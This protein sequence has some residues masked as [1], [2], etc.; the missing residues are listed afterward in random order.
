VTSSEAALAFA[1]L[2]YRKLS[3]TQG[4][5]RGEAVGA[6]YPVF[7]Q[8]WRAEKHASHEVW[9]GVT[10]FGK[11]FYL[12][13]YLAREYAEQG[14]PFDLLE[15]M[16]HGQLLADLFGVPWYPLSQATRLNP[17]DVMFPTLLEQTAHTIRIY[18]TVLGRAL[19]G[20]QTANLERGL[21][22]QALEIAYRGGPALAALTPDIT[23]TPSTVCAILAGLGDQR[24]IQR[25]AR[26]LAD[27][28]AA[29]CTGTG[30]WARFLD[31]PT[32]VS[33]GRGGAAEIGP[34]VFSFHQLEADPV[35]VALAYTQVLSA[36]R[37]DS[38]FD[39]RPRII[40]VDE[41]YRLMRHPALL[42][43]LIEAAKTFRTR[44]KKL[45][46]IDQ[47]MS[48]FLS[49]KARLVFE[50]APV[51]V[52]FNQR[53]GMHVF[54]EDAA[55]QHFNARHREIIAGLPRY[56][57]LLDIQDEGVWFLKNVPM[58]IELAQFATS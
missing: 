25:V 1:P 53:Q 20:S 12:N 35:M 48:V 16:G 13:C 26:N 57:F 50:N 58:Q 54:G 22:A 38:L 39:E 36:I 33:F 10:G 43:F 21:L 24:H 27:E 42:D 55:F 18:E 56:H 49:G 44:R 8:S 4:V 17:Q 34:R 45:I 37:R 2:G 46:S 9:V 31:G 30:P 52:I 28:I 3:G 7:H 29:L 11:T 32:S 14:V 47:N 51:R 6:A 15:P 40:A 23:P 19:G 41:I 5:M